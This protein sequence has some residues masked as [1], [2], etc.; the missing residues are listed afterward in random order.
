MQPHCDN[1]LEVAHRGK[2]MAFGKQ[3]L[4]LSLPY[5]SCSIYMFEIEREKE[6]LHCIPFLLGASHPRSDEFRKRWKTLWGAL[7]LLPHS[8]FCTGVM[9]C[10]R[11]CTRACMCQS[12]K[13]LP[14]Y[15]SYKWFCVYAH[16]PR[17][18]RL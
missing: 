7:V 16:I 6:F 15:V 13:L 14:C 9:A 4:S 3:I 1:K 2:S 17:E 18:N 12:H 5:F 11:V 8:P 10:A